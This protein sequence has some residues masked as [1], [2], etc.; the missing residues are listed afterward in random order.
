MMGIGRKFRFL[1]LHSPYMGKMACP[2]C[3]GINA[4]LELFCYRLVFF[5]WIE[6]GTL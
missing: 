6:E 3:K 5:S 4:Y 1:G 2:P